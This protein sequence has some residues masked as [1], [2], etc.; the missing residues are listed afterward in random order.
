M[1][2]GLNDLAVGALVRTARIALH[3][4]LLAVTP[5]MV[6][7]QGSPP[8]K[9]PAW[10]HRTYHDQRT[11]R[12]VVVITSTSRTEL[13]CTVDWTGWRGTGADST[14]SRGAL[15]L[16]VPETVSA[17]RPSM[18]EG[19]VENI[20]SFE[21]SVQCKEVAAGVQGPPRDTVN[22]VR[23]SWTRRTYVRPRTGEQVVEVSS[24]VNRRLVCAVKWTG[25]QVLSGAYATAVSGSF[26]LTVPVG[27][28]QPQRATGSGSVSG[29]TDFTYTIS[30]VPQPLA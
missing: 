3:A 12:Q 8:E 13:I 4:C 6:M 14:R 16:D 9:T 25:M 1:K 26:L 19:H 27:A 24:S 18:V 22:H 29:V 20:R 21:D 2:S 5:S 30:C 17:A 23:G 28:G 10:T 15:T 7:S 11:G